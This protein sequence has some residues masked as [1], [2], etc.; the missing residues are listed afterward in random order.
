MSLDPDPN[1]LDALQGLRNGDFSRLEPLF[2]A[3]P[4]AR[5]SRPQILD[6]YDEGCF[7]SEPQALA[8][9]LTCACFL[10]RVDVA[11]YLLDRGLDP[12]GGNGTGSN[13]LHWAANCGQLEAVRLLLRHRAPLA[14]RNMY[15]GD[16]LGTV[17]WSVV[18]EPR[19]TH[20]EIVEELLKAG[21]R[22]EH[23]SQFTGTEPIDG[24]LRRYHA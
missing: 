21:A 19:P 24:L 2:V 12:S 16:A 23:A 11:T 20:V 5:G 6:W 4:D 15:G 18:H 17:L 14:T 7:A 1:L 13:F 3:Q 10:G 8:E 9:A 22:M